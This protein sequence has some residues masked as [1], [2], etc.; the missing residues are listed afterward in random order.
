MMRSYVIMPMAISIMYALVAT[1]YIQR[2]SDEEYQHGT[3]KLGYQVM[4]ELGLA[5][6]IL[7]SDLEDVKPPLVLIDEG[8][9]AFVDDE[10]PIALMDI[11]DY[12]DD[13]PTYSLREN[14]STY[15]KPLRL[16]PGTWDDFRE[17]YRIDDLP[18]S[19]FSL[20]DESADL[21]ECNAW[22]LE[23]VEEA[24][25]DMPLS[26]TQEAWGDGQRLRSPTKCPSCGSTMA[27]RLNAEL[28]PLCGSVVPGIFFGNTCFG[29][30]FS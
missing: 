7:T 26:L 5:E 14:A 15:D 10:P 1:W 2:R 21:K 17:P 30:T 22:R 11:D 8:P 25:D 24:W 18:G 28:C 27:Y 6:G 23:S 20:E 13:S 19:M 3:S 4:M 29:K 12:D 16:R 9:V